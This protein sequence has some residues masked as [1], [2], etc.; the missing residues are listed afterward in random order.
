MGVKRLPDEGGRISLV[1]LFGSHPCSGFL[2]EAQETTISYVK[3]GRWKL[4]RT[5]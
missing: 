1:F 2:P 4:A 3:K 5:H